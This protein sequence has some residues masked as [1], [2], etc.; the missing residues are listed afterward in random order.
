LS[1]PP[2][3]GDMA[4]SWSGSGADDKFEGAT[5]GSYLEYS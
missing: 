5:V 3:G 4:S 1:D 2:N